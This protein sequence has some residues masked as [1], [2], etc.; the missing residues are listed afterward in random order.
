MGYD[1]IKTAALALPIEQR[2]TLRRSL[3]KSILAQGE[4]QPGIDPAPV[5]RA[6]EEITG[7]DVSDRRKLTRNCNAR[8]LAAYRMRLAGMKHETIGAA[9][10]LSRPDVYHCCKR[11]EDAVSLP[12]AYPDVCYYWNEMLKQI[13]L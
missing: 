10:G 8:Y 13:P 1:E 12:R 3:A 6:A 11:I 5:I 7:G 4:P 9:L 2:I